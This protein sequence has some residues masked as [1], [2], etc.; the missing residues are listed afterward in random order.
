MSEISKKYAALG[1]NEG[2]LGSPVS[3]ELVTADGVG[4]YRHY[5]HG[6]IYWHP[7][8]GDAHEV[9][10]AIHEKWK[11]LGWERGFLG[12]PVSDEMGTRDGIGAQ[13][14][15]QHGSIY[16]TSST[17]AHEIHGAIRE[18]W[19]SI[20][21]NDGFLGYP[22]SDELPSSIGRGRMNRFQR[23][24]IYWAAQRGAYAVRW[25]LALEGDGK[26]VALLVVI[27]FTIVLL[28]N[29]TAL[30]L[31]VLQYIFTKLLGGFFE[32]KNK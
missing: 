22:T 29:V 17:G 11:N 12:Y 15:F 19:F 2:L 21:K 25:P 3:E 30:I 16:W 32:K 31:V 27:G 6:S 24:S 14:H 20:G 13:S 10:G 5:Q 4:R 23:G 8:A 26:K 1:G 9:H 28:G 18:K 7:E